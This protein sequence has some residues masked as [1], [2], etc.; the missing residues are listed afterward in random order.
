T[1]ASG[2]GNI[3]L[4][5]GVTGSTNVTL[6]ADG[7]ITGT[8][9]VTGGSVNLV[10]TTGNIGTN[11]GSR[12]STAA[13]TLDLTANV[14]TAGNGN[15]WVNEADAVILGASSVNKQMLVNTLAAGDLTVA[16]AVSGNDVQLTIF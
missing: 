4:N 11:A 1:F 2:G 10:S 8:G 3:V 9:T 5:A 6:A 15:A 13:G 16:G 14:A 12:I 7:S